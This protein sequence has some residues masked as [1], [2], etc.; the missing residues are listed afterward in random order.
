[1]I[2]RVASAYRLDELGW[3]QF[4]QLCSHLLELSSGVPAS[5]WSGSSDAWR[6]VFC[7][8]EVVL[9]AT[10]ARL[11]APVHVS[12]LWLRPDSAWVL[13]EPV[14]HSLRERAA[15]GQVPRTVLILTN[16]ASG[17]DGVIDDLEQEL[18]TGP[19]VLVGAEELS[20]EIDASA[21]LRRRMPAALGVREDLDGLIDPVVANEST[22]QRDAAEELASV[23]VA[24]APYRR[25]LDVLERH[26][27]VV[28]T[29]PP[30]MGKT[31]IARMVALAQLSAGWEA[32]ECNDPDDFFKHYR[33]DRAQV[34]VADDA[35]GSTEYRP[36][37]AERWARELDRVLHRTDER[38]WLVWTSRPAPLRAG[39]RRVHRERGLERF[40]APGDVQ[41]DA[42]DLE[43]HEKALILFRHAK[44][45]GLTRDEIVHVKYDGVP[46]VGNPY[47]TPERI[48]R[49]VAR[50]PAMAAL[51]GS[52]I[53]EL[54]EPTEAMAASLHALEPEHRDLLVAM[55]DAP[56]A[57]VSQ[58]E[59]AAAVRRH[60]DGGLSH[61]PAELVDRLADHFLKVSDVAVRWVHPSWRD[62]V[63]E[64]LA[65]DESARAHFLSRCGID[66][67][68]LAI[69]SGGGAAG[70]RALPLLIQDADW[71]LL[72]DRIWR[73]VPELEEHD[74]VRLLWSLNEALEAGAD[75]PVQRESEC[76]AGETLKLLE[77][78]YGHSPIPVS[79]IEPWFA[80]AFL[81]DGGYPA[82]HVE[83]TW[84]ELL[85]APPL[86][87][88]DVDLV[89]RWTRLAEL[90]MR[91][92][93]PCLA[94]L[95]FPDR[96]EPALDAVFALAHD[97]PED[98]SA[99]MA[100]IMSRL[101]KLLDDR[102]QP[103]M[104]AAA[105]DLVA[106]LHDF[107]LPEASEPIA[108]PADPDR[109]V[110][111]ILADL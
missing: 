24:T 60:H 74:L 19:V 44:G 73:L 7:A 108:P 18:G 101:R 12:A 87:R 59:L 41:V 105:L 85:P 77:R 110:A 65:S 33:S 35:F 92:D 17:G 56:V 55:L 83:A 22:L 109:S 38:H 42:S 21:A 71:D 15:L 82:P 64:E 34:F 46:V 106:E 102:G 70:T 52:A 54:A 30:E 53:E 43:R 67:V 31:A 89:D 63:I 37:T 62:L 36:E 93:P 94:A 66:G 90:L 25:A 48:R 84:F 20:Q 50:V 11:A 8:G 49:Y 91:Y 58:R 23:F 27:F 78:R 88:G 14:K 4:E 6:D 1:M 10:G 99:L 95:G 100:R 61:P 16:L 81:V 79:L 47:F 26:S 107:V 96:C 2:R 80:I 111:R 9:P 40:P 13:T 29:G 45:A 97:H 72:G 68:L 5:D 57:S 28:L 69:S 75:S 3:L 98:D 103:E 51:T 39:L 86:S 76:L 104:A 32:H